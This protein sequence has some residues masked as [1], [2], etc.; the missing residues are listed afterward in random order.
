MSKLM[1]MAESSGKR[2][3]NTVG[4]GEIPRNE[5]FFPF[6]LVFSIDSNFR[7]SGLVWERVKSLRPTRKKDTVSDLRFLYSLF[8][9]V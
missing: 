9:I 5:D 3:G 1:K 8:E 7:P 2:V 6:P 4:K